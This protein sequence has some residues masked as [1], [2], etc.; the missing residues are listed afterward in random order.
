MSRSTRYTPMFSTRRQDRVEQLKLQIRRERTFFLGL[1][2]LLGIWL[3]AVKMSSRFCAIEV[4]GKPIVWARSKAQAEEILQAVKRRKLGKAPLSLARFRQRVNLNVTQFRGEEL[5]PPAQAIER[6]TPH[7]DLLVQGH[8]IVADGRA[9]AALPTEQMARET[10]DALL[11]Q[12]RPRSGPLQAEPH[13]KEQVSVSH[14][15]QEVPGEIFFDSP[16]TARDALL[17][18]ND[19][20]RQCVVRPGDTLASLAQANRVAPQLLRE[21]NPEIPADGSLVAGQRLFIRPPKP[22]LTVVAEAVEIERSQ[23]PAASPGDLPLKRVKVTYENGK[24]V[25]REA[26]Q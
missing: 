21:L 24:V 20:A 18:K 1:L 5:L 14:E 11:D 17:G 8:A 19:A 9:L 26:A 6:L 7:L 4:E 23:T 15:S 2:A 25:K 13:F 12:F 3:F 10:L 22:L 16:F